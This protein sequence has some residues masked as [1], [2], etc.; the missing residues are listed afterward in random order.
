[1]SIDMKKGQWNNYVNCVRHKTDTK[2]GN[3]IPRIQT[4]QAK[5]NLL[6]AAKY[7]RH[8]GQTKNA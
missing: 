7:W 1:M 3:R 4:Y 8:N 2:T 5:S 6:N